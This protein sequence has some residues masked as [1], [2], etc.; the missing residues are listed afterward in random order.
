MDQKK[1][2]V[3]LVEIDKKVGISQAKRL[4]NALLQAKK[5]KPYGETDTHYKFKNIPR[6]YF[7]PESFKKK[8]YSPLIT[9]VYGQLKSKIL[10]IEHDESPGCPQETTTDVTD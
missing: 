6:N 5:C 4:S 3:Y 9:L 7:D 10:N 1:F 8:E 2:Y